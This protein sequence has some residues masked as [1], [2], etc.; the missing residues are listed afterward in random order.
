MH[1]RISKKKVKYA[2]WFIKTRGS[3]FVIKKL[4]KILMDFN[5]FYMSG[6]GNERAPQ[7]SYLV[8][9]FTCD[10]N[11]TSLSRSWPWWA[12]TES[13]ACVT[14]LGAVTDWWRSWPMTN[15]LAWLCSCQWWTFWTYLVTVSLFSLHLMNFMFHTTLDAVGNIFNMQCDVRFH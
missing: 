1:I 4:W 2:L 14:R 11:M 3:T 5:D 15:K 7:V 13:A 8:I 12:T 10:V 6:N 9:Y